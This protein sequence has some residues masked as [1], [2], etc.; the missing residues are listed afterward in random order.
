MINLAYTP[1]FRIVSL[2]TYR[3]VTVKE[4]KPLQ[5]L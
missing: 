2:A 4:G 5:G 1:L 3:A